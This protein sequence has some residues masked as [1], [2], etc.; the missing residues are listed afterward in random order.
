MLLL[1]SPDGRDT[2]NALY[3]VPPISAMCHHIDAI[4]DRPPPCESINHVYELPSVEPIIRYLHST[5]GFPTKANW[6]KAIRSVNF[7]SWPLVNVKSF[8]RCFPESKETQKGTCAASGRACA[9]LDPP[10]RSTTPKAVTS[11]PQNQNSRTSLPRS[12]T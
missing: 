9:P 10:R 7:L 12:T 5:A 2:I 3:S 11:P 8:H 4:R 6:L 1:N